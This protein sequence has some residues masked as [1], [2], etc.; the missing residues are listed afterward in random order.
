MILSKIP[1]FLMEHILLSDLS[2]SVRTLKTELHDSW[3]PVN[4]VTLTGYKLLRIIDS[5]H[6]CS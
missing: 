3:P 4:S 6:D 5:H 1:I 2:L